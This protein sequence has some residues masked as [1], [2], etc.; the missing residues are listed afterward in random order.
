MKPGSRKV[1]KISAWLYSAVFTR[2]L[3]RFEKLCAPFSRSL[4]VTQRQ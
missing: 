2:G 4:G 1:A 3:S